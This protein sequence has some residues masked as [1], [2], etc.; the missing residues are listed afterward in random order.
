MASPF[1]V[2]AEPKISRVT[3]GVRVL[4]HAGN[5]WDIPNVRGQGEGK[6]EESHS[7]LHPRKKQKVNQKAVYDPIIEA[8]PVK[9][10]NAG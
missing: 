2:L 6:T 9:K 8:K 7:S 1:W 5:R 10:K 3:A 4:Q